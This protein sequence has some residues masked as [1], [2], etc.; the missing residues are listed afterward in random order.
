MTSDLQSNTTNFME[1]QASIRRVAEQQADCVAQLNDW[2]KN[3]EARALSVHECQK[4]GKMRHRDYSYAKPTPIYAMDDNYQHSTPFQDSENKSDGELVLSEDDDNFERSEHQRGNDCYNRGHFQEAIKCYTQ[5]LISDPRSD[6]AF[7][8][9]G[10]LSLPIPSKLVAGKHCA[11]ETVTF[12][13]FSPFDILN[14]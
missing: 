6:I 8:N 12:L 2:A 5:C 13:T 1:A 10:T 9:R 11:Y 4:E 14:C 7:S 3:L